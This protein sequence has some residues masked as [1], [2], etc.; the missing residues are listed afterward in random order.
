MSGESYLGKW[1]PWYSVR[2]EQ[3]PYGDP[4]TYEIAA[5]FLRGIAVEDWGSGLGWFGTLHDGPY[6]GVDGTSSPYTDVLTD[7]RYYR[8]RTPGL[9][10]RHVLEHNPEWRRILDNA[11]ASA[12]ERLALVVFTPSGNGEELGFEESLGVPELALPHGDI[13]TALVA[14][15]WDF[16]QTT[17]E[18]SSAYGEETCWLAR[19]DGRFP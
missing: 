11:L 7:L 3:Q 15:G 10:M 12:T 4:L 17:H 18:T 19:R 5:E 9:F 14:G 13:F 2:A 6:V 16:E 8:S 1:A